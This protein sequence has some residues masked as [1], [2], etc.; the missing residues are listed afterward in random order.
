MKEALGL[1][2]EMKPALDFV[3]KSLGYQNSIKIKRVET[4]D[5]KL[6]LANYKASLVSLILSSQWII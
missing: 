3:A 5:C 4:M 6:T 2:K 1:L